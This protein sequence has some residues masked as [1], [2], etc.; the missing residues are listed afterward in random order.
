M[1]HQH[2]RLLQDTEAYQEGSDD[3]NLILERY[4]PGVPDGERRI[5]VEALERVQ[6]SIELALRQQPV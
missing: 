1:T 6:N 2:T 3:I 5:G 4:V